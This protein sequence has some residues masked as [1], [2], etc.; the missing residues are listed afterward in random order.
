MNYLLIF[1]YFHFQFQGI[2][3]PK[4]KGNYS[5]VQQTIN[6]T[7]QP[8]WNITFFIRLLDRYLNGY[9]KRRR[10]KRLLR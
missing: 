6:V 8:E 1:V 3:G 9:T 4:L 2:V 10:T 5:N 7:Y